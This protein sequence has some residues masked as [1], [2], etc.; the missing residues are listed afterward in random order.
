MDL[1]PKKKGY[2]KKKKCKNHEIIKA[3]LNSSGK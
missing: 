3:N 2:I 1:A